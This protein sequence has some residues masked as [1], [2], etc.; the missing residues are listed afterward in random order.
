M[1]LHPY[2]L[3]F[4]LE[5]ERILHQLTF[6]PAIPTFDGL[7]SI[8]VEAE[9]IYIDFLLEY[10]L[11]RCISSTSSR[12]N[13]ELTR[14][15]HE[16]FKKYKGWGAYYN[17]VILKEQRYN[18]A[19]YKKAISWFLPIIISALALIVSIFSLFINYYSSTP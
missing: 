19:N 17:S 6:H 8:S 2:D 4:Q 16:V 3:S 5:I 14:K 7:K 1:K 9:K 11:V 13:L 12:W 10:D 15:G 18:Q